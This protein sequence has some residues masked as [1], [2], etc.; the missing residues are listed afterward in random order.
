MNLELKNGIILAVIA[1]VF[2]VVGFFGAQHFQAETKK[3]DYK[4][5]LTEKLYEKNYKSTREL[6][7][8]TSNF[9][10][11]FG[12]GFG[13]TSK[14]IEKPLE[15]FNTSLKSYSDHVLELKRLGTS[16][17]IEVAKNILDW[18]YSIR[19]N[20]QL[21]HDSAANVEN[22]AYELLNI[23]KESNEELFD[24]VDEALDSEIERLI[25]SEN[26]I[27]YS[28][29][30]YK[31]SVIR[32][33]EQYLNYYFRSELGLEATKDMS[34]SINEL[35][36]KIKASN[37]FEFT[38]KLYPFSFAAQRQVFSP[39]LSL[40]N[41]GELMSDKDKYLKQKIKLKFLATVINGNKELEKKLSSKTQKKTNKLLKQDS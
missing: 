30:M 11:V 21:Q 16:E 2:G 23:N 37:A 28:E 34:D 24:F 10:K 20:F 25:R 29:G 17:Q 7:D 27:Y 6:I 38:E 31:L 9:T 22:R 26:R 36:E 3:A 1:S 41:M 15:K 12:G 33:L 35:P 4:L 40:K 39:E 13:L 32:S 5:K 14:E 19:M 18:A 8:S